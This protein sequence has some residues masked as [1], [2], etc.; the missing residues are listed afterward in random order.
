MQ[1]STST[2]ATHAAEHGT[3]MFYR[4]VL[5]ALNASGIPFLVGGAYAF[6]HYTGIVRDTKDLDLFIRRGDFQA[7]SNA[8]MDMGHR[9]ELTY[10]HWLGKLYFNGDFI[11]LIFSSGNG[12]AEVD[13]DWFAFAPQIEMLGAPIRISPV[14]EMIWSKSFIMERERFDGADIAHML[15]TC[16]ERIDWP[17]LL[18]R[19][20][21]HWRVLLSHII[22]FGFIYPDERD[23]V[24]AWV[25]DELLD[26]M[27][28]DTHSPPS[29]QRT[30]YGTL[31]SR[32][33]FLPDIEQWGYR[34]P[35]LAPEGPMSEQETNLWTDAIR[36]KH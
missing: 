15:R 2:P 11:D 24:P 1:A 8:L 22:L 16:S 27:R 14:E 19:F 28:A 7:V 26:R 3:A 35:R 13:D 10:P 4:H 18:Q 17:R 12:V 29:E 5:N 25:T 36:N 9:T 33:Q 31:L 20:D 21:A 23:L 32:E 6:H 30:C 34:D